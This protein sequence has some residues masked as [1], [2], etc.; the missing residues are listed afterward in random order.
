MTGSWTGSI[1]VNELYDG[2]TIAYYLPCDGSG[3]ATLNLT[4]ANGSTTGAVN[5]YWNGVSRVTT[6]YSA[7]STIILTY[8]SAGSISVNGTATTNNRW[9]HAD[10]NW[11]SNT[12]PSAYCDTA[13]ATAAKTARW[14]RC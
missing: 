5:V 3:N 10:Y 2:L 4:L 7:G 14:Q 6:H 1:D 9:T 12:I 8:W 13:A 11:N